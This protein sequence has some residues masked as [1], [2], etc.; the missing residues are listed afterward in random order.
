MKYRFKTRLFVLKNNNLKAIVTWASNS[1]DSIVADDLSAAEAFNSASSSWL[2]M[3]S[4][5]CCSLT[6]FSDISAFVRSI[7]AR[8]AEVSWS[9][10]SACFLLLSLSALFELALESSLV[11]SATSD[12]NWA[13]AFSKEP[14][15]C[16][17]IM[18]KYF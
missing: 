17:R 13:F 12:S 16:N 5:S 8:R 9:A 2:L 1:C 15:V 7:S 11:N 6:I 14:F 18:H 3:E 4:A 10:V